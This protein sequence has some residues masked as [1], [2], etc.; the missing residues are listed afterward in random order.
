MNLARSVRLATASLFFFL[1]LINIG[2][3]TGSVKINQI[4]LT[5][6]I[7][8]IPNSSH[9]QCLCSTKIITKQISSIFLGILNIIGL[10]HRVN[11]GMDCR[12]NQGPSFRLVQIPSLSKA[13]PEAL[14]HTARLYY[15]CHLVISL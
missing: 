15:R 2:V 11:A 4:Y 13:Y 14:F 1:I 3:V 7:S 10:A 6:Y 8:I 12:T 5:N 9:K